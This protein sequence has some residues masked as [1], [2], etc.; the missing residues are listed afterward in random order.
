[1][2]KWY[3]Y[4]ARC[5]DKSLYIGISIDV[6]K[7]IIRHNS[8]HGAKWIKQH[9]QA[10]IVYIEIYNTYLDA[11][12]RELQIKKWSRDKKENLIKGLKP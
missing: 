4:I 5:E 11:H 6:K 2:D 9:G 7:R 10:K 3:F 1:M 8:G 12:R